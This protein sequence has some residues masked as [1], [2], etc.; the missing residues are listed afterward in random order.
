[1]ASMTVGDA[2]FRKDHPIEGVDVDREGHLM[3][4]LI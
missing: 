1:M 3:K 2:K 4:T